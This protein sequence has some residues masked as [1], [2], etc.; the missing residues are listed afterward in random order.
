MPEYVAKLLVGEELAVFEDLVSDSPDVLSTHTV[1]RLPV[2][3]ARLVKFGTL[4]TSRVGSAVNYRLTDGG[5]PHDVTQS[6]RLMS[7]AVLVLKIESQRATQVS[8][9]GD[10]LDG[11][12]EG[13]QKSA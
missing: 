2:V 13:T 9:A 10:T 3:L 7:L 5:V 4:A 6:P 12:E 1:Q 8:R 11:D